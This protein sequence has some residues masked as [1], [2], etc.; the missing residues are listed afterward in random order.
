LFEVRKEGIESMSG[1]QAKKMRREVRKQVRSMSGIISA[2]FFS[3]MKDLPLHHR[4]KLAWRLLD[5]SPQIRLFGR[6]P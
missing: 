3:D 4:L 6:K 5:Q 1:R 2:R